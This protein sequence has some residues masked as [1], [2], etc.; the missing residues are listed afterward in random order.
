MKKIA[1]SLALAA[2]TLPAFAGEVRT[3]N[4]IEAK[5]L[6]TETL[7]MVTYFVPAEGGIYE[8]TATWVADGEP[9]PKRLVLGLGDGDRVGFSLP[10][11]EETRFTFARE[12]DA[13]AV[14]SEPVDAGLQS[15]GL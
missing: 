2:L 10:G 5:T 3:T 11:H 13:L 14:S 12:R 4:P 8:V 6:S 15:A 1:L 9:S 7:R